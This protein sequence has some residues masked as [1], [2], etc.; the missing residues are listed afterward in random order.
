MGRTLLLAA[1]TIFFDDGMSQL[2]YII[3]L[4]GPYAFLVNHLKPWRHSL[5]NN[6]DVVMSVAVMIAATAMFRFAAN[7]ADL[8]AQ[9]K[10]D[11]LVTA[12]TQAT[13]FLPQCVAVLFGM[14]LVY[15]HFHPAL[16]EAR[17]AKLA[18]DLERVALTLSDFG[19]GVSLK[20]DIRVLSELD[21]NVLQQALDILLSESTIRLFNLRRALGIEESVR[22]DQVE[23]RR[24]SRKSSRL[25]KGQ[26]QSMDGSPSVCTSPSV[27]PTAMKGMVSDDPKKEAGAKLGDM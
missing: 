7:P 15:L 1:S 19:T 27:S 4:M 6:F 9:T 8:E 14:R 3:C 23:D 16:N 5:T 21:K 24:Q 26:S 2:L 18:D 17:D 20:K 25:T 11:N 12:Y 13:N 22:L 10:V